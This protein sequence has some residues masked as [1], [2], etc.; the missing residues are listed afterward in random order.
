MDISKCH[1][2]VEIFEVHEP[3]GAMKPKRVRINGIEVLTPEDREVVVEGLVEKY[4]AATITL[5]MF[6]TSLNVY[7]TETD[8]HDEP[9]IPF[10]P[11]DTPI[12]ERVA[13]EVGGV[14]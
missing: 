11:G 10:A 1:C 13:D 12:Y 2:D 4:G 8:P 6:L 9:V 5:T 7:Q 14:L 3:C